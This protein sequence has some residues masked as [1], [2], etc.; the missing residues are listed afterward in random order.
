VSR[1]TVAMSVMAEGREQERALE[2]LGMNAVLAQVALP[3]VM[4]LAQLG[5]AGLMGGLWVWERKYSRTREDQLT[6]AHEEILSTREHLGAL[7]DA[8]QGNTRVI[9]EF[10]AVQQEMLRSLQGREGK[11]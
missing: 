2:G 8:L 6:A 3:E 1:W 11:P 9:S 7:L 5:V 4:N 10:T